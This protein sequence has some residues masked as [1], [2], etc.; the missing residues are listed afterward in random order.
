[1]KTRIIA[2]LTGVI[3]L[4]GISAYAAKIDKTKASDIVHS[5]LQ[6]HRN[7]QF[8]ISEL[9][10]IQDPNH[11]TTLYI[12]NLAPQGYVI[13]S[14]DTRTSPL[15][16]Y[17]FKNNLDNK[18]RFIEILKRDILSRINYFMKLDEQDKLTI[19][20]QWEKATSNT[21]REFF[22]QWPPEGTTTSGGWIETNWHQ[23]AP[24]NQLCPLDGT[25]G[26]RS[27]TGCPST[28]M[29]MIIDYNRTTNNTTFD[30]D[31][32]YLHNYQTQYWIDD[33][34]TL[35]DFPGFPRLNNYCIRPSN[36]L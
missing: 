1:M 28:A 27:L 24:Y 25:N 35:Y 6:K 5:L 20:Q 21:V 30:E 12:A 32:R 8:T 36:Q 7:Y 31:D 3:L 34:S 16:A 2:I 23:N 29:A 13:M 17:S 15:I 18:G 10:S 11:G 19:K 33:D 9:Y 26:Q 4:S 14:A 22:Q